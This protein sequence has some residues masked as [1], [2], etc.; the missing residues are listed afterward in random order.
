[1]SSPDASLSAETLH[2]AV[3]AKSQAE[4]R[5]LRE[6][7]RDL[8]WRL[9]QSEVSA[10]K[11]KL[12]LST[13]IASEATA[14]TIQADSRPLPLAKKSSKRKATDQVNGIGTTTKKRKHKAGEST[15]TEPLTKKDMSFSQVTFE[16]LLEQISYGIVQLYSITF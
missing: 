5:A 11:A 7:I 14:E 9:E 15:I 10:D 2:K 16:A 3:E 1:M 6:Q 12:A 13:Q 4:I 8:E